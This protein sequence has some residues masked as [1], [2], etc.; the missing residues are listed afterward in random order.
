MAAILIAEDNERLRRMIVSC[1]KQNHYSVLEAENGQQALDLL[2]HQQADLIIAD[3]MMPV[4]DGFSLI[5]E[6]REA[7]YQMP[8]LIIT[9]KETLEDKRTGFKIG[10]DDY[11]VK[12]VDLDEL[13]LRV[14]ALLRRAL[15]AHSHVLK[16]GGT[17]LNSDSLTTVC[18]DEIEVLPQK[19]FLLLHKL[20]SY[21]GKIFTRQALM[22]EIWGFDNDSAPRTV[23]VHVMRLREKYR[24]N[25][26]FEIQ[27]VR[28]LG[29]RA[30]I[31]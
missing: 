18:G 31:K 13:L 1:L 4:M 6:L 25:S 23:D 2:E 27:T 16:V 19:E 5:R 24:D 10:A 28:G 30:V 15:I 11:M 20:L 8:V 12:P 26:D 3:I 7:N 14:E 22:D 9:A 17:S 21:P 29:Y